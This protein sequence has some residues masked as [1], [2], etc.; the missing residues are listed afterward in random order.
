M[1][2][3]DRKENEEVS[4]VSENELRNDFDTPKIGVEA[5]QHPDISLTSTHSRRMR[6]TKGPK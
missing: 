6:T 4:I 3:D 2:S 1:I 5:G